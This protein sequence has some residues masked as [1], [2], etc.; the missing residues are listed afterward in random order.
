MHICAEGVCA[1]ETDVGC[2][3]QLILLPLSLVSTGPVVFA[4]ACVRVWFCGVHAG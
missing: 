4:C 2:A 1:R 3:C